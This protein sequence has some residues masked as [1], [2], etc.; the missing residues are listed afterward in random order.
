MERRVSTGRHGARHF[1]NDL[2]KQKI[3]EALQE[4]K[5]SIDNTSLKELTKEINK[6]SKQVFPAAYQALQW[7]RDLAK[8]AHKNGAE[9]LT[10][11]TPTGDSI[12]CI[13][14]DIEKT[15]IN[16]TFNGKIVIGD[17]NTEKPDKV[18]EVSSFIP[19]VVH[20]YD[21]AVLKESF[22]DWQHPITLIHDDIRVLPKDMDRALERI[23]EGFTS[24]VSG[25]ALARL[26]DDL[27]V[28][29]EQL[30]RLPQLDGELSTVLKSRYMFN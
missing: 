4:Q 29:E 27:G 6:A 9:S 7:L 21:A 16:T 28:S 5:I 18:K 23:R 13:K 14:Y 22:N 10:W 12:H 1:R 15:I 17:F 2:Q 25:D 26:A 30:P 8:A 3:R 19:A 24:V 11:S 20:C